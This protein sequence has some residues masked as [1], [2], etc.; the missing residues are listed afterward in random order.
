M[1]LV[2]RDGRSQG[3]DIGYISFFILRVDIQRFLFGR[4]KSDGVVRFL[5]QNTA[6]GRL[7]PE[8]CGELLGDIEDMPDNGR[9]YGDELKGREYCLTIPLLKG[10]LRSCVL[11]GDSL[12]WEETA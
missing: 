7:S 9:Y 2:L 10:M 1:G 3:Y 11:R 5:L 4:N 8:E 12:E 6:R